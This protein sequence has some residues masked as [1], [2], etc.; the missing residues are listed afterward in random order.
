M[1]DYR[2]KDG[3]QRGDR[4]EIEVDGEPLTAHRGETIAAA[5]VAA[6]RLTLRKT[7][8][9]GEPRG[10]Y[11]G[12][13]VCH[14]CRMVVDGKPNTRVCQTSVTPGC[15]VETQVAVGHVEIDY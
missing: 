7:T 9:Q 10:M 3:V 5:L 8:K 12:I 4:F 2:V 13:G 11:C 14:E 6:G 1:K 15:R